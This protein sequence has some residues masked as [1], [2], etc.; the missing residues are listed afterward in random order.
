MPYNRPMSKII[1][2]VGLI[3]SGKGTAGDILKDCGFIQDAFASGVKDACT[4]VFG[5]DRALLE[6]DT[7]ESRA[8]REAID[9]YWSKAL[10]K[11]DFT[12]RIALQWM[13]TEAGR[14]VFGTDLWVAALI[15]R[16]DRDKNYVITDARFPNELKAIKEA[17]GKNIWI[18][19]GA[20]PGWYEDALKINQTMVLSTKNNPFGTLDTLGLPHFSEWAWIGSPDIYTV[21]K[22]DGTIDQLRNALATVLLTFK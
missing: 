4:A 12:P 1:G 17:G 6:G 21:I 8:F 16:L 20:L 11:P 22:N 10:G 13:G 14:N 7:T 18:Q 19:R 2:L 9:P 5:W 3:G 15:R